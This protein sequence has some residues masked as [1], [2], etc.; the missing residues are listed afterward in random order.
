VST[1]ETRRVSAGH[2]AALQGG[3]ADAVRASFTPKAT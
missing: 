3:D 2:V 1:E